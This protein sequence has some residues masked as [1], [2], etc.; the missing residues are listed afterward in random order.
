[1]AW[2]SADLVAIETAIARGVMEVR[3]ADGR[4]VKYPSIADLLKARSAILADQNAGAA[5][6]V[7]R[8]TFAVFTRG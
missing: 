6:P 8:S 2:T 1:M 7:D 5:A 4:T 3:F